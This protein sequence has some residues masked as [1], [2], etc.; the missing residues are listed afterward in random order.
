VSRLETQLVVL[1]RQLAVERS[2][3]GDPVMIEKLQSETKTV[4]DGYDCSNEPA[5]PGA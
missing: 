1:E 2:I 5:G 4:K 3:D